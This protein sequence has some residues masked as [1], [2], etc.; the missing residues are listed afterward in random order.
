MEL[1]KPNVELGIYRL[2]HTALRDGNYYL[3]ECD[4][5]SRDGELLAVLEWA[6]G[7]AGEQYPALT[8]PLDPTLLE[9]TGR[10]GYHTYNGHLVDPRKTQ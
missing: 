2:I 10:A 4:F 8:V 3:S 5:I 7:P 1:E 9:E 6:P